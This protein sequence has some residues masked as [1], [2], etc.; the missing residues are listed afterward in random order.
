MSNMTIDCPHCG[1]AVELTAALAGPLLE[2]ERRKALEQAKREFASERKSIEEEAAA[3]AKAEADVRIAELTE[4]SAQKEAELAEARKT[5]LAARKCVEAVEARARDLDLEVARRV[6]AVKEAAVAQARNDACEE[7]EARLKAAEA[8]LAETKTKQQAAEQAELAALKAKAEAEEA[9]RTVELTVTR[10]LD[11]ERTKVRE[12]ALRER[13]DEFRLRLADK[14]KQ[15]N[16]LKEKLDEAQRKAD[17]GSQQLSGEVLE[18]DLCEALGAAFPGDQFERV[19][20][21]Q[22]GGDVIHTVRSASGL[23]CGRI[24]WES[25]RTQNWIPAWLPKLRE[26]QRAA[27][28]ELAALVSE[29][30]PDGI[31]S[32]GEIEDVWVSGFS[33]ALSMAALLRRVLIDT[34][35]ARRIAGSAESR[36]DVVFSY[37]TGPEFRARVR[38]I[39]EPIKEMRESLESEKRAAARIFAAREK[40]IERVGM[41]LSGMYGD[42]QGAVGP[43]L[44]VVE[45]LALPEPGVRPSAE[46]AAL[47]ATD[48]AAASEEVH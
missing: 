9:K 11:E 31:T 34:A 1:G 27:K 47:P 25:K 30:L 2:A 40:Q 15:L 4:V 46:I 3:R 43:S 48:T 24:K 13:D 33:T 5:E 23:V 6:A 39:I 22:K 36:K 12:Q 41:T 42:L 44:P 26:D 17:Q 14:D 20:K 19:K 8:E 16:D 10:R 35:T 45:G 32:F 37:L 7:Y 29:T 21:G 38:G 18:V 28:C